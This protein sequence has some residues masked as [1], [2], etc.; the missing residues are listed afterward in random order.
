[1]RT[2]SV[3][4]ILLTGLVIVAP[5]AAQDDDPPEPVDVSSAC[6]E[7]V[8]GMTA[9]LDDVQ[10]PPEDLQQENAT[11]TADDFDANRFF[12]TLDQLSVEEG[13]YLD[14]VYMFDFMGG[15]PFLYT[16]P[17][18]DEPFSTFVDYTQTRAEEQPNY[19][20]HVV[21][22]DMPAGYMQLAVLD[23]MG[24]QFYLHWHAGYN[25]WQ[26]ICDT[27]T[28]DELVET[29]GDPSFGYAL[30]EDAQKAAR[31]ID[32]T[33]T[34]TLDDDVAE[35]RAILFTKW[36]GFYEWTVTIDREVPREVYEYESE[37]LVEY[38]CGIMF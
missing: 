21:A 29:L 35:V 19:L 27:E 24:E 6:R 30:S 10:L 32:V 9:L 28:L 34:V 13:Y 38:D 4:L 23:V 1:M 25:D 5:V 33:P 31:E 26:I 3:I 17:E 36:G 7:A 37:T 18:A 12:S 22:E 8:D 11:V 2:V 15:R 14:Y 20:D 16:L